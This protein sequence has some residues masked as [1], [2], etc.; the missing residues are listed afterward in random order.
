MNTELGVLLALAGGVMVGNCMVP[1]NYLRS[2]RWEKP[3]LCSPR[4]PA[5]TPLVAGFPESPH[6]LSVYAHVDGSSFVMPFV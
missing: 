4:G 6:L 3:G 5:H 1:L 2:W